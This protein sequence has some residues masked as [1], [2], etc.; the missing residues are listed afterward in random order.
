MVVLGFI[1]NFHRL[2][3]FKPHIKVILGVDLGVVILVDL[4][5]TLMCICVGECPTFGGFLANCI[6]NMATN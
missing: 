3:T 2:W 4:A 6:G 5:T 1:T